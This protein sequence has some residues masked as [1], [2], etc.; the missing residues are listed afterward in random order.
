MKHECHQVTVLISGSD[1][2]TGEIDGLLTNFDYLTLRIERGALIFK[3]L[4][5][6]NSLLPELNS[7]TF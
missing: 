7:G 3:L 2:C 6:I 4:I 5:R 1:Y